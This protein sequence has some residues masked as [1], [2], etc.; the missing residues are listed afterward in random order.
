MPE[1]NVVL[2]VDN[3]PEI[4]QLFTAILA[5][6]YTVLTATSGLEAL[7][8]VSAAPP[9][10]DLIL[11]DIDMPG[12]DGFEVC[13]RL[14]AEAGTAEIPVIFLTA[15]G[16]TESQ[17]EGF[18]LGAADF[19]SKPFSAAVLR[20]RVHTHMAT[21]EWRRATR[22]QHLALQSQMMQSTA[23]NSRL[24]ALQED[25]DRLTSLLVHDLRAPLG[26]V[27]ANLD[28]VKGELPSDFD[29]EVVNALTEARQVTDRLAGM[30]GDLLDIA[31]LESGDFPVTLAPQ[32]SLPMLTRLQRQLQAQGRER[33]VTV[34]LE[35]EDVV[36]DADH[37]LLI[38]TLENIASNALRYTPT[39]GRVRLEGRR[40]GDEFVFAVRNNGPAIP[41][42][43]R[44]TL[45][46]KYVQAGS[47][48]G[49][50]RRVGWG[51]G[52]YFCKLC[53]DAHKG[54]IEVLEEVDWPTSFIVRV[55]G[56][57]TQS[58]PG[59]SAC[60]SETEQ[61]PGDP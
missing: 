54:S 15:K 33:R 41:A 46:D 4:T 48:P 20:A 56:V 22:E 39:G 40:V 5:K 47:S 3:Q 23:H 14:K 26:A 36:L 8:L 10:P 52:L 32:P 43:A 6:Q 44:A 49:E 59:A 16:D 25:K 30:I 37:G 12:L 57:V 55:P 18:A 60:P 51:L 27:R 61:T 1:R 2:V 34:E 58:A 35:A 29:P 19:I 9:S 28:W 45:F 42:K 13:R 21:V 24:V 11:L 53:V 7:E 38:R 17:T 31:R 50:N